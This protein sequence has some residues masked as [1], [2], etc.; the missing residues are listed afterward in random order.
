[1]YKKEPTFEQ[2]INAT[3]VWCRAWELEELSDE[4]LADRVAELL[5]NKDGARGF[6]AI[7]LTSN[8]PLMDRLPE[9][10]I[11]QLRA[12]GETVVDLTVRNM[13][14]ST[15]MAIHHQR[16]RDFEQQSK[17][18]RITT[19]SIE[20]LRLLEPSKVKIRLEILLQAT[21]HKKGT[22]V[23]FLDKWGYDNEQKQAISS[24]IYSIAQE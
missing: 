14:M 15:A 24:K 21:E 23:A 9:T 17:S 3:I 2:A 12:A 18:E 8:C 6:F 7:S 4:V 13:A 20:I 1:M 22:D 19:R 16:Q 5:I 10:L 11:V